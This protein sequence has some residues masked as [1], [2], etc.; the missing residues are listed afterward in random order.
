MTH[1]VGYMLTVHSLAQMLHAASNGGCR[2]VIGRR[3]SGGGMHVVLDLGR[4]DRKQ[5]QQEQQTGHAPSSCSSMEAGTAQHSSHSTSSS[6]TIKAIS[7]AVAVQAAKDELASAAADALT[8]MKYAS[9]QLR[10]GIDSVVLGSEGLWCVPLDPLQHVP[11]LGAYD[12]LQACRASVTMH[13]WQP[14]GYLP[15][16]DI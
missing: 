5:E 4:P 6:S 1:F 3:L 2:L 15:P 9:V 7:A 11:P 10:D 8:A 13:E 16:A 14:Q 12:S